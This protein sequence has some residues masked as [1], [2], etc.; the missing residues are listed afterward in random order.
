MPSC[1]VRTPLFHHRLPAPFVIVAATLLSIAGSTDAFAAEPPTLIVQKCEDFE[2]TGQGDNQAWKACDWVS[3]NRRGNGQLDYQSRFKMLYSDKGVYVL[4]DGADQTLTATM[5]ADFLDLWNE[6]VFECFFWTNEK[7]PV[8]FE[9]EISPLGFELPILVPNLDGKFLGWRPWHYEGAKKIEKKVSATGGKN[10]SMSTVTGWRA[11]VFLPYAVLEP[12]RNVPPKTGTRWRAN[13]YRVDYDQ[14]KTTGW[15]WARVGPSFHDIENFGTLVFGKVVESEKPQDDI[16]DLKLADWQPKSMLKTKVTR[17]NTPSYPVIDVHN[18]LGGGANVLTEERVK[19]YLQVMDE[20]NVETVINLDGGWDDKL[21]ETVAALD[22]AHPGRFLTFALINLRDFETEGW[23]E[24]ET[25]RL[26]K[27][28]EAGAKGLKFHKSLGLSY[29]NQAGNLLTID[30]ERLD[31]IWE[32]CGEMKRPVMIH[33]A[34]PAAFFTPL[35]RFNERWHELNAHPGWVF[36]GDRYPSREELL[37]QRNRA[38]AKHPNTT[39]IGAHFGNN[40][41]DLETVGQ[42]LDQYPNFHIDIDARIS[43]LGRQPYSSRKFFLKYQDRIMFGTDTTPDPNAYR[44]YY[45]FLETDDEYFD[46]AESHHRQGFWNIYGIF[47]PDT[48]LEKVYR[49]NAARILGLKSPV[50]AASKN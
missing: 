20:A 43:E 25:A 7:D 33:T 44:L 48:V 18:H 3:L 34:D 30:D 27:S 16:R 9:Y 45:R 22:A 15:D 5:Q 4:F 6:D 19:R 2:V 36:H 17:V 46:T 47:L 21:K 49:G 37:E 1:A 11:E 40:P 12:L 26:R 38:I 35:D 24:R 10:E 50:N 31:P 42:W 13:F 39:F 32:L 41:E 29:R 14:K 28:F 23:S 8:Y